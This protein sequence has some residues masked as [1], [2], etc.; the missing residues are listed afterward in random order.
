MKTSSPDPGTETTVPDPTPVPAQTEVPAQASPPIP[1]AATDSVLAAAPVEDA[2][3]VVVFDRPLGAGHDRTNWGDPAL[4]R[5]FDAAV[6]RGREQGRAEGYAAGWAQGRRAAAEQEQVE[7]VV[8]AEHDAQRRQAHEARVGAAIDQLV[9]AARRLDRATAPAWTELADVIT[10]GALAIARA[11]LGRELSTLDE[12]VVDAVRTALHTLAE[13]AD[14]VLRL[15][16]ADHALLEGLAAQAVTQPGLRLVADPEV[17][18]SDV[19][20][21]TPVQRLRLSLPSAVAAAEE[22]L[23]S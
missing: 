8:R 16:P 18:P 15:N 14:V 12:P 10:D 4:N 19:L 23:R 17:E 21:L 2:V 6:K 20:A 22:V 5:R 1:S 3:R 7:L 11:A 13:P 9:T